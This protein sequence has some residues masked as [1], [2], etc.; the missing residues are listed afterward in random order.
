[1][2]TL[3]QNGAWLL[4]GQEIVED[5]ADSVAVLNSKLGYVPEKKDAAAQTMAYLSLIHI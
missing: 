2:I 5:T 4:N 3:L 1:M